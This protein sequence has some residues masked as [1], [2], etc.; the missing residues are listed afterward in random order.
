[1]TDSKVSTMEHAMSRLSLH[2]E[3]CWRRKISDVASETFTETVSKTLFEFWFNLPQTRIRIHNLTKGVEM[4]MCAHVEN[5]NK[6]PSLMSKSSWNSSSR[7]MSPPRSPPVGPKM[8]QTRF[9]GERLT[10]RNLTSQQPKISSTCSGVLTEIPRFYSSD[11][12]R[13]KMLRTRRGR[14][15][16]VFSK[17]LSEEDTSL[18]HVEK[19]REAFRDGPVF[20]NDFVDIARD[21]WD[22]PTFVGPLLY[23]RML[24]SAS[25]LGSSKSVSMERAVTYWNQHMKPHSYAGRIFYILKEDA[26]RNFLIASDFEPV[27]DEI[28]SSHPGLEFLD[29]TPEFQEKYALTCIARIFYA[30]DDSLRGRIY[31]KSWQ[32]GDVAETFLALDKVDDVNEISEGGY[33]SYEHFYVIYCCF[34]ELD[35]DHDCIISKDEMLGYGNHC[36]TRRIVDRIFEC[37]FHISGMRSSIPVCGEVDTMSYE[38]FIY[39][40]LAEKDKENPVSVRYWFRLLDIDGDGIVDLREMRW[41]YEEQ[42]DRMESLGHEVVDFE[43]MVS[44]MSDLVAPKVSGHFTTQD[45]LRHGRNVSIFFDALFNLPAFLNFDNRDSFCGGGSLMQPTPWET[46]A[47]SEYSRLAA[48]EEM[49]EEEEEG[50]DVSA[51]EEEEEDEIEGGLLGVFDDEDEDDRGRFF[52]K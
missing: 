8:G 16:P 39:F 49:R 33:F 23:R 7:M 50:S 34:W 19:I 45:L 2:N 26:N 41:F 31:M 48:E 27:M 38:R 52:T 21:L 40:F 6:S 46:F 32:R 25:P 3:G 36:L 11:R 35:A 47:R 13:S 44:Q 15:R 51:D 29:Q 18:S 12:I 1:M 43:D 4:S 22:I 42:V 5:A 14:W 30:L 37:P 17:R 20:Q 24:S 10:S 28:I 9:G